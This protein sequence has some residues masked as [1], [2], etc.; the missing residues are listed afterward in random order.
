MRHFAAQAACAAY[1]TGRTSAALPRDA[2]TVLTC[3]LPPGAVCMRTLVRAGV[4]RPRFRDLQ[5][6]SSC[7]TH[8]SRDPA[9]ARQ[10]C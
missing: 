2:D 10:R 1:A 5:F 9:R 7:T 6:R 4:E 8:T 3:L